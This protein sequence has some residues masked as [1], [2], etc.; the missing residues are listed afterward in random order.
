MDQ[1]FILNVDIH[2]SA[3]SAIRIPTE[4]CENIIDM[5][6]SDLT[7]FT[8]EHIP[9]LHNCALVCRS[10]RVRS[11]RRLFYLVQLTNSVSFSRL[12]AIL[13]NAQ[14]LR[15]YVHHIQLTGYHLHNTTS[16]F[17]L[18]PMVFVRKLPNLERLDI[19]HLNDANEIWFPRTPDPPKAKSLPYIPLHSRFPMFLSSF[20]AMSEL[21]LQ[22]TTFR[23]FTELIRM[24]RGLANLEELT[25]LSVRWII[26]GGAHP[27]ADLT[28]QPDWVAKSKAPPLFASKLRRFVVRAA[29]P[30]LRCAM[31]A[32][33]FS[34]FT[35]STCMEHEG[36]Y[37]RVGLI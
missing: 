37:G 31:M 20:T 16:I 28:K 30:M 36:S 29:T 32:T 4:V 10:W 8:F 1:R 12:S 13:D 7:R 23:S 18:F 35:T 21:V 3:P 17:A 22:K 5:L 25:C 15:D 14:H 24:L 9:T 6:Y 19:V 26:A 34:S 11:Q 27:G 2:H 33:V